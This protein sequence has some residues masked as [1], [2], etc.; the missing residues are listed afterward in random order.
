MSS[1]W[2]ARTTSGENHIRHGGSRGETTPW[3][4]STSCR[5]VSPSTLANAIGFRSEHRKSCDI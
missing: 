2:M 4:F 3:W 5:T 1:G